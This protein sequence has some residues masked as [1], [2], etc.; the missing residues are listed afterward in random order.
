MSPALEAQCLNHWTTREVQCFPSLLSIHE[1]R[2][3]AV[4]A[5]DDSVRGQTLNLRHLRGKRSY[6]VSLEG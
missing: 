2:G 5:S 6:C 3:Y 1:D 4:L